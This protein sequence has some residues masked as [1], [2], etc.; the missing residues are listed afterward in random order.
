MSKSGE[1]ILAALALLL[2]PE[3]APPLRL[4]AAQRLA[5]QGT[6]LLPL[7][8][9]TLNAYPEIT[10]PTWPHWPAQYEQS[11]RLLVYLAR[12]AQ[13]RL[14]EL[15]HSPTLAHPPG[16]VLWTSILEATSL[17][18]HEDYEDLACQGLKQPWTTVRIASAMT[19]ATRAHKVALH[20]ETLTTLYLH[21]RTETV[22]SVRLVMAYALLSS[23]SPAGLDILLDLTRD[24]VTEEI[25]KIA[26]FILS[27]EPPTQLSPAQ[28]R[29]LTTIFL[30]LLQS[31]DTEVAHHA[32]HGL[33]KVI[34]PSQIVEIGHLMTIGKSQTVIA[35]LVALEE[36]ANHKHLR[37][38]M[39]RSGIPALI[40]PLIHSASP[41]IRRQACYTLAAC[42]GEYAL[43]ALGTA[44]LQQ[45]HIEAIESLRL[46]PGILTLPLRFTVIRWLKQM[47]DNA[48][49]DIQLAVL[50]TIAS[51][52]WLAHSRG[53]KRILKEINVELLHE[54]QLAHLLTARRAD[55]RQAAI[56]LIGMLDDM[57]V[58]QQD[59][60]TTMLYMLLED[61][62]V[63]VRESVATVLGQLKARWAISPLLQ[64]LL[65]ESPEVAQAALKALA[66]L[67]TPDDS[68]VVLAFTELT[69]LHSSQALLDVSLARNARQWLKKIH[70][71]ALKDEEQTILH[72]SA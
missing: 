24:H 11:G 32:A 52:L 7:L 33:G 36:V 56:V 72:T 43:A 67:A 21:I 42:G 46:L 5:R 62:D 12:K 15:L 34:E 19:L 45:H 69:F 68:L 59:I 17:L 4:R 31:N 55:I 9:T 50:D 49:E 61:P 70:T 13:V 54:T 71:A 6:Q 44:I 47:L 25:R 39:R 30:R 14:E 20:S 26:T 38:V 35:A 60:C 64:A 66:H 8:L 57:P 51:L 48:S 1:Q 10:E 40:L 37:L 58:T 22:L 28:K 16:P 3:T 23:G 27:T 41:D 18:P 2:G 53:Y 65:D 63:A 29:R